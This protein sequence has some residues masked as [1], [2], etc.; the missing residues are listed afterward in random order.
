MSLFIRVPEFLFMGLQRIVSIQ[1]WAVYR[2][3]IAQK[4]LAFSQKELNVKTSDAVY[5]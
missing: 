5:T 2:A 4:Y 3:K 1:Y